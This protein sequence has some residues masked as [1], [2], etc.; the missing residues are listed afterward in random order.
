MLSGMADGVEVVD[1]ELE[2]FEAAAVKIAQ[3]DPGMLSRLINVFEN[4]E[5]CSNIRLTT[6]G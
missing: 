1:V 4:L 3:R 6:E 2:R 5:H